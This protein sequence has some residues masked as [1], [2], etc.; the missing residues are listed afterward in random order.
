MLLEYSPQSWGPLGQRAGR[1][2]LSP[3]QGPDRTPGGHPRQV[4]SLKVPDE[5]RASPTGPR[6]QDP[7]SP[8]RSPALLSSASPQWNRPKA[9]DL[10]LGS[11]EFSC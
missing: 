11:R 6:D 10:G 5:K 1:L 4:S 3:A 2:L 8:H 9:Y 7:A